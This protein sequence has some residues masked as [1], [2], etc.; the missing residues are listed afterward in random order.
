MIAH[1]VRPVA[2]AAEMLGQ[3]EESEAAD[4]VCRFKGRDRVPAGLGRAPDLP[5]SRLCVLGCSRACY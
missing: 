3:V 5:G 4:V 2:E 1:V